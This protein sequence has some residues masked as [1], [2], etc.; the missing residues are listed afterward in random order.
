MFREKKLRKTKK[1]FFRVFEIL[2]YLF[3]KYLK[4]VNLIF[5]PKFNFIKDLLNRD[6]LNPISQTRH[7][8][9]VPLTRF[10]SSLSN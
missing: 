8:K 1:R 9:I 6:L 3:K 4:S 10:I 5:P 2:N 7:I